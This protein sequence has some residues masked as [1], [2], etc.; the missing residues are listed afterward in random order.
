VIRVDTRREYVTIADGRKV[1]FLGMM[2]NERFPIVGVVTLGNDSEILLSYALDGESQ[3]HPEQWSL[4]PLHPE[5]HDQW[6]CFN[7]V[8]SEIT[9]GTWW[10]SES[11]CI[12]ACGKDEV[13]CHIEWRL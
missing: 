10:N 9:Q 4:V 8:T 12:R 3:V 6:R 11:C 2:N 7:V 13:P 1:R 5:H